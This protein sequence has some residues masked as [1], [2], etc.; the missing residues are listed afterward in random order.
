MREPTSVVLADD[1]Y[2]VR[3]GTR[4]LLADSGEITVLDAVGNAV[5]LLH[6]VQ[7]H[8]PDAVIADIRMP[9]TH[10]T[11][12]IVAAHRIRAAFPHIGVVILS[13]H[14]DEQYVF[15]LFQ[16][17]TN[18]L[19]YLLKE[20]VGELDELVRAVR[21]VVAGRSVV[22]PSIV[23]VLLGAHRRAVGS[24]LRD[25]TARELEVLRHMAEGRTNKAIAEAL[26][27]SESTVEKHVNATFAK[28]GLTAETQ[29]HRRVAAVLTYLRAQ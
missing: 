15:D 9:P 27:L 28:L 7:R 14:A 2:L 20:R 23:E 24:P 8:Q 13:Q 29:L 10:R 26:T 6:A 11:E 22:D 5:E 3:E 18:G 25:L 19:A 16:H 4:R 1:H 21:E 17:G 12:G